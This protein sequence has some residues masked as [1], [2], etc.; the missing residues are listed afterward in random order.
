MTVDHVMNTR[1]A[2]AL[3][4]AILVA[5][6]GAPLSTMAQDYDASRGGVGRGVAVPVYG[7]E[8]L[9]TGSIGRGV[10]VSAKGS[11]AGQPE[12]EVPQFGSTAGGPAD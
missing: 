9:T 1:L 10:D 8:E 3:A 2:S 6:A 12:R 7:E 11:N 4:A 5:G